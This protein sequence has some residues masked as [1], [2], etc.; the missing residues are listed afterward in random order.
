MDWR[1]YHAFNVWASEHTG[2]AHATDVL[3]NVAIVALVVGAVALWFAAR[4]GGSP[5]WKLGAAS[6]L[7]SGALGYLVNQVIHAIHDRPRPY[8][9]H[10]VAWH[11]YASG[12]DASFPSDHSSAAFGIAWGVFLIDRTVGAIFL[13]V[14]AVMDVCRLTIGAHYPGDLLAGVGV[15]LFVAAVVVYLGRPL[16]AWLVR[17]VERLTD[18]LV[19]PLWRRG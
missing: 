11:P 3:M 15:G 12:T 9:T 4:P 13:A 7:A 16:L 17:L 18:P 1:I 8:E 14:A 10:D 2:V 5:R 19:R 6:A